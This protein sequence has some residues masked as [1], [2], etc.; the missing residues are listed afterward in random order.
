MGLEIGGY[1]GRF[2]WPKMGPALLI[3]TALIF[4]IRTAGWAVKDDHHISDPA[5]DEEIQYAARAARRIMVHLM[6]TCD[7]IFPQR[8]EPWYKADDEDVPQ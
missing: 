1:T 5:L 7:A 2:D 6:R 3:A 8:R 4:A